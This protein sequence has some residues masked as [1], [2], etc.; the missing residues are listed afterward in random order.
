VQVIKHRRDYVAV[1]SLGQVFATHR[2]I[3]RDRP[4]THVV[5]GTEIFCKED[6]D[7][8]TFALDW[9]RGE[10]DAEYN[11]KKRREQKSFDTVLDPTARGDFRGR[12]KGYRLLNGR[13]CWQNVE[14]LEV[15]SPPEGYTVRDGKVVP[16]CPG[17]G[18]RATDGD[19]CHRCATA[20]DPI[21]T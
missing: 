11:L 7:P 12:Y 2:I 3:E 6:R 18:K 9:C 1:S 20:G 14:L 8:L 16:L 5:V 21:V 17:C 13:T 4:I 10:Q 15:M 19:L